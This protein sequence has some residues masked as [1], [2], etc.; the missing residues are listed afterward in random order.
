[1]LYILT[2]LAL[3]LR[4][5]LS[6][7]CGICPDGTKCD[8]NT[9]IC[10]PF[11]QLDTSPPSR[12][13]GICP[14]G[15]M[16][17][18]NTG[19]CRPFRVAGDDPRPNFC[20]GVI[21][22]PGF[23]CDNNTGVCRKFRL[24]TLSSYKRKQRVERG[25]IRKKRYTNRCI[26]VLC[27]QGTQCDSNT[28]IC[29]QFRPLPNPPF[30]SDPCERVTC[31]QGTQCDSN[32][33]ICRPFRPVPPAASD[34]CDRITCPQGTTC[35]TNT[36]I[37]RPFRPLPNPPTAAD[38]CDGVLCPQGTQC[39]SNT[40][41]CRPF[42]PTPNSPI[43]NDPC[44]GVVCPQGTNCDM[45]TGICRPFRPAS[46]DVVDRCQSVICPQGSDC[47]KNTGTCRPFRTAD[48]ETVTCPENS[49]Y[50][51]CAS[52]CPYT[53]TDIS[54][55]CDQ[56]CIPTC[57]CKDG[58]VQA[59][60]TDT[61]CVRSDQCNVYKTDRCSVLQ[62][63]SD[64][65]CLEGYCNPKQCPLVYLSGTDLPLRTNLEVVRIMKALNG[66]IN[67]DIEQ[68]E[69]DRYR[70]MEGIHPPVPLYKSAMSVAIPRRAANFMLR[71]TRVKKLLEYLS[72]TW[73]PDESFWT[74]V[75]GNAVLL[76]VPGSYRARDILW[77][78][79]HLHMV[80]PLE[81]SINNVGTSYIGRYQVWE[82]ENRCY[83]RITSWSCV[84]GVLDI[85]T[86]LNRPEL[87]VHKMYLDTEPAAF[88]CLLKE[89]R[90]RS[91]NP[92]DFDARSYAEMPTVELSNGKRI[93]E[94]THPEWLMRSSF[95][96]FY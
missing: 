32:T 10:R 36:G 43:A 45:N 13:C 52:P 8:S 72:H 21:C 20:D 4:E 69:Q 70:M 61:T 53:C 88:M 93:T 82:R 47:D 85:P 25:Q 40:G 6:L 90:R 95:H 49:Y 84:F 81:Q 92:I 68:F 30:A 74:S 5:T 12:S 89:L 7:S 60:I 18:S 76:R 62:C 44:S 24:P 77:L 57:V 27:P 75:A 55:R 91:R 66:S 19:V 50:S 11:R 51:D 2:I 73:I 78:R 83:G 56:S 54:K 80:P 39:D 58:F 23:L 42:R 3:F 29:R 46:D 79:K 1:M 65:T 67:T 48:S 31:P 94:L 26:S 37:C 33:G 15:T 28:G 71:S 9:G 59:S 34:P 14:A 35:D 96:K 63:P 22:P 87:I 17:D 64:M 16:C 41:I 38:K 86:L